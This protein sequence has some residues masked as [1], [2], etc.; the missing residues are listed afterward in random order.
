M[1]NHLKACQK[2]QNFLVK[3]L[4]KLSAATSKVTKKKGKKKAQGQD[5]DLHQVRPNTTAIVDPMPP[6]IGE[7]EDIEML[8]PNGTPRDSSQAEELGML[9]PDGGSSD[10]AFI[11]P[12]YLP[13]TRTQLPHMPPPPPPPVYEPSIPEPPASEPLPPP[14]IASEPLPPPVIG[15]YATELNEF[16]MFRVYPTLP[17]HEVDENKDINNLCDA[18][19]L[20]HTTIVSEQSRQ[21]ASGLLRPGPQMETSTSTNTNIFAPFLNATIYRLFKWFYS[22][23]NMKSSGEVQRLVD[24]VINQPDFQPSHLH[25]FSTQREFARIDAYGEEGSPFSSQAGW[26]TSSVTIHL[27]LE[28]TSHESES[29]SPTLEVKNVQHRSLIEV[30]KSAF[31]MDSAKNFHFTPFKQ[32]FKPTPDAVPERVISELYNSD[33]FYDEH[34]RLMQTQAEVRRSSSEPWYEPVIAAMMFWSDST[35]LANFG[36]ASLWPVYLFFGNLSKY[37]RAKP[38]SCSAHHVAYVPSLP[39]DLQDIYR[40]IYNGISATDNTITFLKRELMHAIWLLM[41]DEEFVHAYVHGIVMQCADGI[42][43]RIFPRIFTYSADY[44]EKILLATIK[45]LAKCPCPRCT[46]P[47]KFIP[48]LGTHVDSQR[49]AHVRVDNPARQ[50]D[51]EAARRA[52]FENGKGAKSTAVEGILDGD[53]SV[54]IRN[55]FSTRLFQHGFNFFS[56]LVPDQMHEFELGVWKSTFTHL[57]R[58]FHVTGNDAIQIINQRYRR[59][60]TF[61]VSTIQ[62]FSEN[63]SAMTKLAARDFEDL[64]QCAIPVFEGLLSTTSHDKILLDLLFTLA[65]WHSLAKLRLHTPSTLSGLKATTKFL[66]QYLRLFVQRV[67]PS[68]NTKE[69]P[70]EQAARGRKKANDAKRGKTTKK[71]P[72]RKGKERATEEDSEAQGSAGQG[73]KPSDQLGKTLNLF[74]YKLHALGDYVNSIYAFGPSDNYSTQ[75][76]ELEHRKVK[77]AYARTNKGATFARQI[78]NHQRR[79]EVIRAVDQRIASLSSPTPTST[80]PVAPQEIASQGMNVCP[81]QSHQGPAD[82]MPPVLPQHHYQ[83]PAS[84]KKKVN[85]FQWAYEHQSSG[86]PAFNNFI[87]NLKSHVLSRILGTDCKDTYTQ[88][89]LSQV[90]ICNDSLYE[91]SVLRVNYT[92]YDL[93]RSQD[94]FNPRTHA[95][96]LLLSDTSENDHPFSY[97]RIFRL[98]HVDITYHCQ[99]GRSFMVPKT[100]DIAWVRWL[101]ID[102]EHNSG[103]EARRLHRVHFVPHNTLQS[104]AFGF[105]NPDDIIRGVHLIPAFAHGTT[106]EYLST[107]S[108]ARNKDAQ[109]FIGAQNEDYRYYY[110]NMFVDRDMFMRF[111]GG[112]IGHQFFNHLTE[113]LRP[114]WM[115]AGMNEAEE[116]P[117]DAAQEDPV[118]WQLENMAEM[119]N[120][121]AEGATDEE[122][123]GLGDEGEG[124]EEETGGGLGEYD[125]YDVEGYAAL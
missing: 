27:P 82:V 110:V 29:T 80:L 52:M 98:F 109:R 92:T 46:T 117:E 31:S 103:W 33:A 89:E 61:G 96:I 123:D 94:S 59:I 3:N 93:R 44:P 2:N 18:P 65:V 67:C 42:W 60:P 39:P 90:R 71:K 106:T 58:I 10:Q 99:D 16:N 101:Q 20:A 88:E 87:V 26:K 23:S 62:R 36:N 104:A 15:T 114:S 70:K 6:I 66:G 35:H 118:D 55:A 63:V 4:S 69:L 11:P 21:Q 95:D 40:D 54:P 115:T 50:F 17:T 74:T 107:E 19:G 91:H 73:G 108:I 111:A 75:T 12:H 47:K 51:I 121:E 48:A 25:N 100:F 77:R 1:P 79:E 83:M 37:T 78:A 7:I 22:G 43:R 120:E 56:M 64:L 57:M 9:Q 13:C 14:V 68:Y 76:G 102:E 124:V 85:I 41:L 72:S 38:S 53:S 97:A 86:D 49:R 119:E 32:Y 5:R 45:Y 113:S 122:E 84:K 34:V 112:G 30:I 8:D 105:V 24:D 81:P 28:Q 125:E 116:V